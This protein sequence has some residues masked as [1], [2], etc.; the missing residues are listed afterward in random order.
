[1]RFKESAF[2][3]H[4]ETWMSYGCC[5]DRGRASPHV[6][7]LERKMWI[8]MCLFVSLYP[9]SLSL[10][11]YLYLVHYLPVVHTHTH[12]HTHMYTYT[13]MHMHMHTHTHTHTSVHT[14]YD[15]H[16]INTRTHGRYHH[17]AINTC[18][19]GLPSPIVV[20]MNVFHISTHIL[21]KTGWG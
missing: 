1:M 10:I 17:P 21:N 18:T 5:P 20:T 14:S 4:E 11:L 16:T 3:G 8:N 15:Y 9:L 19:H 7:Y 2:L 6:P 13:H 12:T